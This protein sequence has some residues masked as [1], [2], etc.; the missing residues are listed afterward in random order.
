MRLSYKYVRIQGLELAANTMYAKRIF[1]MCWQ[2]IQNDVMVAGMR[3]PAA[4]IRAKPA[5]RTKPKLLRS[6][7]LLHFDDSQ[8]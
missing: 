2:L 3:R 5:V 1:S 4:S 6:V 8:G 7:F